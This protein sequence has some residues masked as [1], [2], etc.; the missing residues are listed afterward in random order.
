MGLAFVCHA[1]PGGGDECEVKGLAD[2][3]ALESDERL[4]DARVEVGRDLVALEMTPAMVSLGQEASA[5]VAAAWRW[6]GNWCRRCGFVG[7]SVTGGCERPA[8]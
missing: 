2:D 6:R 8:G 5:G 4:C 3:Q 1:V 7:E